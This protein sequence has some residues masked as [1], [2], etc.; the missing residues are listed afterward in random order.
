MKIR[1]FNENKLN[2]ISELFDT[3][4]DYFS[5][6]IE[7]EIVNIE[8]FEGSVNIAFEYLIS[9]DLNDNSF[10]KLLKNTKDY[11]DILEDINAKI[12]VLKEEYDYINIVFD[13]DG[14][15]YFIILNFNSIEE[16]EFYSIETINDDEFIILD[17][18]KM[19]KMLKLD[20]I[21]CQFGVEYNS[22]SDGE[23]ILK[24]LF[25]KSADF[26]DAVYRSDKDY[27]NNE[28]TEDALINVRYDRSEKK[29][30]KILTDIKIEGYNLFTK[31]KS[32]STGEPHREVTRYGEKTTRP[33]FIRLVLN[34][35]FNFSIK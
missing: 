1:R 35:K 28:N 14:D 26:D 9:E 11:L 7:N 21:N 8:I 4:N 19:K 10:Q 31:V 20:N 13:Y 33:Y 6:L 22:S 32:V 12:S 2:N 15:N 29:L 27:T 34:N 5:E 3:C 30:G 18:N 23:R 25:N 17:Y 16:K 24:I